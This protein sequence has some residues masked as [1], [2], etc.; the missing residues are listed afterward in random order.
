MPARIGWLYGGENHRTVRLFSQN[1]EGGCRAQVWCAWHQRV[2]AADRVTWI[3]TNITAFRPGRRFQVWHDR[4]V[5]HFLTDAGDRRRYVTALR[6]ALAP[7]GHVVIATFGLDGPERCSGLP[8]QRY[9]ATTLMA[10]IGAGFTLMAED[11]E[12]HVTPTGTVQQ[13]QYC[14]F[15]D[16]N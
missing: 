16:G 5:F 13:F 8:V 4:A 3:E 2:R 15:R 14:W 9:R 7:G 11:R 6:T 1:V 10:E 12:P